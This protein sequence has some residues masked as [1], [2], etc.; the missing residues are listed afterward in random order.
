MTEES[1][2]Q[3]DKDE[4]E[5]DNNKNK[6]EQKNKVVEAMLRAREKEMQQE[7][8]EE[9]L[10]TLSP[11][12]YE[13]MYRKILG[14]LK[15]EGLL[16]DESVDKRREKTSGGD[17]TAAT[18]EVSMVTERAESAKK[19]S[20]VVFHLGG[21][22]ERAGEREAEGQPKASPVSGQKASGYTEHSAEGASG[23]TGAARGASKHTGT[24]KI[25]WFR[26]KAVKAAGICLVAGAAVFGLSMTSEANRLLLMQTANEVLGTGDLMQVDNGEDRDLSVG[27]EDEARM[28]I[29][30]ALNAEVPEFLYLPEGMS[31]QS[32]QLVE[33][34]GYAK[35][36]YSYE[37]GYIH[38]VISNSKTDMSQ[39]NIKDYEEES[40][41]IDTLNGKMDFVIREMEEGKEQY[42]AAW[43]YKNVSYILSGEI[44][45]G[46]LIKILEKISYEM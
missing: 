27:S 40:E 32:L 46:E 12:E 30:E 28:E 24:K 10:P 2:R 45:R 39:G 42:S 15:A 43:E 41:E 6:Q 29:T 17:E 16:D 4:M 5:M 7:P 18:R 9:K 21:N 25:R 14:R 19:D 26:K 36:V 35:M 13:E 1:R 20:K 33:E 38:L 23:K 8:T 3:P 37:R 11:D 22:M 34:I 44:N 31:Y